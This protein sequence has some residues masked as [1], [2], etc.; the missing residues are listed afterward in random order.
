MTHREL[1]RGSE[2]ETQARLLTTS[3]GRA[4]FDRELRFVEVDAT[5]AALHGLSVEE[6]LGRG[7]AEILPAL[8][9][10]IAPLLR[11]VID[12]GHPILEVDVAGELDG[13]PG[14][15]L[16]SYFP[17][18]TW[19]GSVLGV[20]C[21]VRPIDGPHEDLAATRTALR[22]AVN[23]AAFQ[24]T[25]LD[26]L[27]DAVFAVD[28]DERVT[29]WGAGAE[30]LYGYTADEVLGRPIAEVI[31]YAWRSPADE[32]AAHEA[33]A[34]TGMWR[35]EKLH[36]HRSGAVLQV[37]VALSRFS[38]AHGQP[39]GQIAVVRDIS[40]RRAAEAER[41]ALLTRE[42]EALELARRHAARARALA[43]AAQRFA[44][45][46]LELQAVL[47]QIA[48]SAAALIGDACVLMLVSDDS[49]EVRMA[50]L[51][52][53]DPTGLA[54]LRQLYAGPT[55]LSEG[56]PSH[57]V[58]TGQAAPAPAIDQ[59]VVRAHVSPE[60][61]PSLD[62]FGCHSAA[63]VPLRVEGATV[64]VL[65]LTRGT[66]GRAYT[67]DDQTFLEDLAG[68]A[69]LAIAHARL[70]ER[71]RL[72]RAISDA[73]IATAPIG[74]AF[75]DPDLRVRR[76]NARLAT[77]DGITP[78][79]YL[80]RRPGDIVP[81]LADAIEPLLRQVL[82]SGEPILN[83]E[84]A[85]EAPG[86]PGE[87]RVWSESYYPIR[88]V[89]GQ[90]LGVGTLVTDITAQRHA[91]A[92]LHAT[93]E[94]LRVS[95]ERFAMA[96]RSAPIIFF[97]QDRDHRYTWIHNPGQQFTPERMIGRS[98]QELLE[99]EEEA[100]TLWAIKEQVMAVGRRERHDVAITAGGE[101][102]TYDL[103]VEPLRDGNG[104]VSGVTCAAIDVTA[105]RQ[106]EAERERLLS[107]AQTAHE[108]AEQAVRAR[109]DLFALISHDLR[110]PLTVVM[111]QAR[112]L[113]QQ[114]AR[115]SIDIDRLAYGLAL[116][117]GA[118]AQLNA[119]IEELVDLA[120]LKSGAAL[121]LSR[122]PIDLIALARGVVEA[123]Q[124][125]TRHHWLRLETDSQDELICMGDGS[126]IR[127]V[128]A[129]LVTNAIAYSPDGGEIVVRVAPAEGK[130]DG[131]A[132]ISV[133]DS[134]LGIPAAD[135]PH[136]F[137][138]FRRGA[139]VIERS[140]GT[141]LGLASVHHIVEQHR[142][143]VRVESVEGRGSTFTVFLPLK[144]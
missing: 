22:V 138:R 96:L 97:T 32:V 116:I 133:Q 99:C 12:T 9:P 7:L 54:I 46:K 40:A 83:R 89:S 144:G 24:A 135:L 120:R 62:Q 67:P 61:W 114:L 82:A 112:L 94:R 52:H 43:E 63:C 41:D 50:A 100:M 64:G 56:L 23:Q 115:P 118:A 125:T 110:N 1:H 60:H 107:A 106:A 14:R 90:L 34:T 142:G 93:I 18:R 79:G 20:E 126:R 98:D 3:A 33:L 21:L 140:R 101:R 104:N 19:A 73:L 105:R 131:W 113:A 132:L 128:I 65:V 70:F 17:V 130:A 29:Y 68:H 51:H 75:L 136:I 44:A 5:L 111:A 76:I 35:G 72:D 38:D 49:R 137:E 80:G 143:Q 13:R 39:A 122:A 25:L 74:F 78:E 69:A 37:E 85:G 26:R 55:P 92:Q 84:H 109:D 53:P 139:N 71:A 2:I 123:A 108:Q 8:E 48:R 77:F 16:A 87:P 47:D 66:P 102:R 30:L 103:I 27:N 134:G 127:R 119:Q 15:W 86:H 95:E 117:E 10:L 57:V 45:Q 129:N 42:H 31:H 6:H 81:A 11:Q 141:G 58:R 91:E 4:V 28:N 121:R 88:A 36:H 124:A 59:N